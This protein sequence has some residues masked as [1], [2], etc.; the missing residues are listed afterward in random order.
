MNA[1]SSRSRNSE[2]TDG[3]RSIPI[4]R[5]DSQNRLVRQKII[6]CEKSLLLSAEF[7]C[8]N[9][10]RREAISTLC[11]YFCSNNSCIKNSSPSKW[12]TAASIHT[13]FYHWY[14][15]HNSCQR[16]I[17][18]AC[19]NRLRLCTCCYVRSKTRLLLV[20]ST[21]WRKLRSGVGWSYQSNGFSKHR[22]IG[23]IVP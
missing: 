6:I 13:P 16:E 20:R 1:Q 7:Q 2:V 17:S 12:C 8:F 3:Q 22:R 15:E 21:R 10:N 9:Q 14:S 11:W 23:K 18:S 4:I 5:N 19:V